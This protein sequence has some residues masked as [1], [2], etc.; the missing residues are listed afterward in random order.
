VW[1]ALAAVWRRARHR[2]HPARDLLACVVIGHVAV[3]MLFEPDLGSYTRHLSSVA[4][5]CALQFAGFEP[6]AG[7][8]RPKRDAATNGTPTPARLPHKDITR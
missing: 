6:R 4:L 1:I 5:L 3:S 8:R 7:R 2:T